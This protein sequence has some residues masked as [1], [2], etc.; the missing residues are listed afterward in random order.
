MEN[1]HNPLYTRQQAF[2]ATVPEPTKSEFFHP[3]AVDPEQRASI[4]M[5]QADIGEGM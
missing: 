1:S 2:L 4:W 3:T 5:D